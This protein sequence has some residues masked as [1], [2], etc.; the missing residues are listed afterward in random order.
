MKVYIVAREGV[1]PETRE[2]DG[3]EFYNIVAVC[4]DVGT[5]K[6]VTDKIKQDRIDEDREFILEGGEE[7]PTL[8]QYE[9][10]YDEFVTTTPHEVQDDGA[11]IVGGGGPS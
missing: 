7:V 10:Y 3:A 2:Q 4:A 8:E 5:A 1:Y 11:R 6:R 9:E